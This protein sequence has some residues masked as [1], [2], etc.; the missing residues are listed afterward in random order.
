[1]KQLWLP[2]FTL[3]ALLAPR[4]QGAFADKELPRRPFVGV[5]LEAKDNAVRIMQIF[6]DSSGSRSELK[7]GDVVLAI[8]ETKVAAVSDFLSAMKRFHTGDR[9]KCR[10]SRDKKESVIDLQLTEWPREKGGDFDILYDSVQAKD[11]TL[12]CIVTKPR[13]AG[14][15]ARVPAVLYVQGIDCGSIEAP[16]GSADPTVQ[17]VYELTRSGFA[18]MRC[19]KSGV[20]D[21]TGKP[22]IELGLH[23]EVADFISALRKLKSC[24]FIDRNKVFLFGHSAGG[25]VAPLVASKEP[26]QGIIVYGTVVRPFAEYLVENR[27]RNQRLR[28]KRDPAELEAEIRRLGR[29]LSQVLTEKRDVDDVLKENPGLA[30]AAKV[31]FPTNQKLVFNVRKLRYFRETNDQNMAQVWASLGVPTLALVGEF[32]LRTAAFDHEYIAETV[33]THHPGKG[34]WKQIPRMDHGF[35]LHTSLED[36]AQNEFKGPLGPQLVLESAEWMKKV[37]ASADPPRAR[38]R[39]G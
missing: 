20:G 17:M 28:S 35:A 4:P 15:G 25:W 13:T 6:P 9:V 3:F 36:S 14:P 27:R 21:S 32:D 29:F 39:A 22:C 19:E 16:I 24:D 1:M 34:S 12:R 10:I 18:V 5:R 33:N 38:A 30:D 37:L 26:V 7:V 31:V 8:N 2:F 11:A 23:E